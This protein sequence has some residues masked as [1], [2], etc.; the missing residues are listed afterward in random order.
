MEAIMRSIIMALGMISVCGCSPPSSGATTPATS[1]PVQAAAW[2]KVPTYF[3]CDFGSHAIGVAPAGRSTFVAK[4]HDYSAMTLDPLIISQID[5]AHGTA[6][7]G[8]NATLG[9]LVQLVAGG[10]NWVFLDT[11][12]PG[13]AGMTTIFIGDQPERASGIYRAVGSRHS[14]NGGGITAI[15]E[16]GHCEAV[17]T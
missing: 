16:Y 6:R 4:V 2:S 15:Q 8:P 12:D 5:L 3:K 14:I 1:D 7:I 17:S 10:G 13:H 9:R 11:A